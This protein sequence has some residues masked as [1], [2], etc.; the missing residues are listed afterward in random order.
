MPSFWKCAICL[1][2]VSSDDLQNH[3]QIEPHLKR[4]NLLDILET[5]KENIYKNVY[6]DSEI[7]TLYEIIKNSNSFDIDMS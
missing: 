2:M 3:R 4:I 6:T 7:Y 5:I 1:T